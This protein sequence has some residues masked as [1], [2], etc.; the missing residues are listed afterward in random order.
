MVGDM[1]IRQDCGTTGG[2]ANG[3]CVSPALKG[4]GAGQTHEGFW[5][6]A[7]QS[8]TRLPGPAHDALGRPILVAM[9]LHNFGD[10]P[11]V[12]QMKMPEG[13]V[14]EVASA[15]LEFF[16]RRKQVP[17]WTDAQDPMHYLG[18]HLPE[19]R[20]GEVLAKWAR[21]EALCGQQLPARLSERSKSC[22]RKCS[23]GPVGRVF[24]SLPRIPNTALA[25]IAAP[26]HGDMWQL[27]HLG[28]QTNKQE[29]T[30]TLSKLGRDA[31]AVRA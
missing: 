4:T 27:N 22:L 10:I 1:G 25:V 28:T 29:L 23:H 8:P 30:Q 6:C 17:N 16:I 31:K 2:N 9:Q 7:R 18:A 14:N 26:H 19:L 12:C 13:T 24:S 15:V 5:L 3:E 11:V 21:K 20:E